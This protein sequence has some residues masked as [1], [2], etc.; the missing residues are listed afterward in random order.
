MF[1]L[2]ISWISHSLKNP[3]VFCFADYNYRPVA[4]DILKTPPDSENRDIKTWY[5]LQFKYTYLAN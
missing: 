5:V 4:I 3:D 2:Q 1:F